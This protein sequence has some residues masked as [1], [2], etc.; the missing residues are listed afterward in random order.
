MRARFFCTPLPKVKRDKVHNIINGSDGESKAASDILLATRG[1]VISASRFVDGMKIDFEL[2]VQHPWYPNEKL[3]VCFQVKS[4]SSHVNKQSEDCFNPSS[5]TFS[6]IQRESHT[7]GLIWV[8][9]VESR[10]QWALIRPNSKFLP[11]GYGKHHKITPAITFDLARCHGRE[12]NC[13]KYGQGIN[14]SRTKIPFEKQRAAASKKYYEIKNV[15]SPVLGDI[16]ITRLGW[17]HMFRRKRNAKH[18][19][20]TMQV[21]PALGALLRHI[22]NSHVVR[23]VK[24]IDLGDYECRECE[25]H[26]HFNHVRYYGGERAKVIVKVIEQIRYPKGWKERT[27]LSQLVQRE[28]RLLSAYIKN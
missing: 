18:K 26:L 5:S 16:K 12:R 11:S 28:T 20:G 1:E 24:Y 14:I 8:S 27:Y 23:N 21:I 15:K 7:I 13:S 3:S 10:S 22:P 4:G 25:H 9:P 17:R 2:S 19:L 6:E